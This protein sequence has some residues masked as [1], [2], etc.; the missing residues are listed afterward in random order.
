[1]RPLFIDFAAR[2]R[3]RG[4]AGVMLLGAGVLAAVF[5]AG[6]IVDAQEEVARLTELRDQARRR[7]AA[8]RP[9]DV[10]APS[11]EEVRATGEALR[12]ITRLTVPWPD[13]LAHSARA[14][15]PDVAL[16][17]FNPE[18]DRQRVLISGRAADLAAALAFVQRLREHSGFTEAHLLRHAA[19]AD[20]GVG[21]SVSAR[22]ESRR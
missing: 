11:A 5:V 6:D 13:L 19:Q 1:M 20:G 21:F 3:P 12:V 2:R 14:A 7:L 17:G 4:P 8:A 18:P 10:P 15:L 16:T 9:R 22:W